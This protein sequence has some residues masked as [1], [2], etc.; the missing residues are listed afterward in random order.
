[1][2]RAS[3]ERPLGLCIDYFHDATKG[4]ASWGVATKQA[5]LPSGFPG[6]W[7]KGVLP[8][9]GR[10]RWIA[11]A[12]ALATPVATARVI[13]SAP[14]GSGRR[15]RIA[16][17]RGGGDSFAIRFPEGAKVLALGLPGQAVPIPANGEPAK[18]TLRCMG[19]SCDGLVVE[20]LLGTA[21]P[22]TAELFATRFGLPAQGAPLAAAR[23]RNAIPQYAPDSTITRSEVKL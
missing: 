4:T 22:V 21:G 1:M 13:A 9:N 23:R 11:P 20:A 16:L 8:Y 17:S 12:P 14:A 18:P 15:I 2:P 10:T 6:R 7:H 5:P 19:R 3:A